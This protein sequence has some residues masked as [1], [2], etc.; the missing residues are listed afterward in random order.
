[1]V[2]N[3]TMLLTGLLKSKTTN[4][5]KMK[6]DMAQISN[7]KGLK[8]GSYYKCL[9]RFFDRYNAS[10]LFIDL[11]LWVLQTLI[12]EVDNFFW[13]VGNGKLGVSN[14]TF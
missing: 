6:D 3:V 12:K 11:L 2:E 7:L 1:M 9:I 5:Y 8:S 10:R 13:T 4:L 14:C